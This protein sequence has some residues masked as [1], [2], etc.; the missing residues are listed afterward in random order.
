[1]G[2]RKPS[3]NPRPPRSQS[4][5]AL[6]QRLKGAG[7]RK[8]FVSKALLPDW[9]HESASEDA[10][11]VQ[12]LEIRVARF[13][14]IAL[15]S[16]RNPKA[17]LVA[18]TYVGAQLR[19][20]HDVSRDRLRPAIHSAIRIASA[21]VRNLRDSSTQVRLPPED[22][23]EWRESLRRFSSRLTLSD[24]TS[25]LW[26]RGIPVVPLEALPAPSFQ[27][28]ACIVENRPVILLG[29]KHDEPGR[30]AFIIAHETEH[31]LAGD[32]SVDGPVVDEEDEISDD[33]DIEVR[34]DAY[35]KRVLLGDVSPPT[36][37][38]AN[39]KELANDASEFE[40]NTGADASAVVFAWARE[41]GNYSTATMAVKALYR[42]SGARK[43]LLR[44]FEE[45]VDV[46]SASETDRDL[47]RCVIDT[48]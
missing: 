14:N 21:V 42:A 18:P 16:V 40:R 36:L 46:A 20:V 8:E 17:P 24:L 32:C 7:F 38:I 48:K 25:D 3:D 47:L 4:F 34:A 13:L 43:Q 28:M 9:W 10:D 44:I 45:R 41:T 30:T 39:F 12:E 15:T 1:M 27:G 22:P 33:S 19:R 6:M 2:E 35:A 26:R 11:L 23:L 37:Q 31:I 5:A 29:Y